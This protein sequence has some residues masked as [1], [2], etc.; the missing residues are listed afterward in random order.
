MGKPT[1]AEVAMVMAAQAINNALATLG[2]HGAVYTG[3]GI[4]KQLAGALHD[5]KK[6][7]GD[8]VLHAHSDQPSSIPPSDVLTQ[9]AAATLFV[10]IQRPWA[11]FTLHGEIKEGTPESDAMVRA[12]AAIADLAGRK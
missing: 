12:F 6:E 2:E 10:T 8:I 4:S 9:D 7:L 5:L 1:R 11:H 3:S